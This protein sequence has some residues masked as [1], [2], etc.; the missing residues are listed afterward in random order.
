MVSIDLNWSE[1]VLTL[2]LPSPC[3]QLYE[4]GEK[5]EHEL[6]GGVGLLQPREVVPGDARDAEDQS[7]SGNCPTTLCDCHGNCSQW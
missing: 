1:L 5:A 6:E 7:G 3:A 2:T 4:H